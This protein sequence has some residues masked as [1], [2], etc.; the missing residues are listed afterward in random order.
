MKKMKDNSY[1][2]G[3]NIQVPPV[4]DE[5][6]R[7]RVSLLESN[8]EELLNIHYLLRDGKRCNDIVKAIKFWESINES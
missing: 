1:L 5:I 8:L 7:E 3:E 6:I 2:Y 4:P